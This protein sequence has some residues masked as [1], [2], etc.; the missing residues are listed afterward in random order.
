MT[1]PDFYLSDV[2]RLCEGPHLDLAVALTPTPVADDFISPEQLDEPQPVY[3]LDLYLCRDCGHLQLRAVVNPDVLFRNY[4]Y[5]TTSSTGLVDHFEDVASQLMGLL[6]AEP[7]EDRLAVDIGSND[8]SMLR[9]FKERGLRVLGIDPAIELARR[10][11]EAG[12]ETLP[13]YF[14]VALAEKILASHGT[15]SIVTANNVFAH[16]DQLREMADGVARLLGNDGI[17]EFEVNYAVDILDGFLF[18][19]VYHEHLCYHAVRPLIRF[20]ASFGLELFKVA[21]I[22]SKGGSI[23]CLVQKAGG[24]HV[25]DLSVGQLVELETKRDLGSLSVYQEFSADVDACGERCRDL[26]AGLKEEGVTIFGY[27]ASQTGTTLEYHFGLHSFL[28]GIFDDNPLKFGLFSPGHHLPVHDSEE[29]YQRRPD[30]IVILAWRYAEAIINRHRRFTED[31]GQFVLP[32]PDP[33]I[34]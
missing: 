11:T 16:S 15:A 21:R 22:G 3:P 8:G 26:L 14:G 5:V 18:D 10:A 2:C 20:L 13:E 23:R 1:T 6:P 32:C 25:V 27:G 17:F 34:A 9:S 4:L 31:G 24:P 30:Y 28:D 33:R 7:T 19:T 12:L 29:I